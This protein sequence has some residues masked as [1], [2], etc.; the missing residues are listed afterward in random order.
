MYTPPSQYC[1][2]RSGFPASASPYTGAVGTPC[3]RQRSDVYGIA[4]TRVRFFLPFPYV[5]SLSAWS[6]VWRGGVPAWCSQRAFETF[7]RVVT[8]ILNQTTGHRGDMSHAL[9]CTLVLSIA[10]MACES[11][12]DA[13]H[14][15]PS[16]VGRQVVSPPRA[17]HTYRC[18]CLVC[19]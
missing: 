6:L 9:G 17:P 3:I 5:A 14:D 8:A 18:V 4:K 2:L 12:N 11:S 1:V 19:G 7:S 10:G 16:G 13:C 15:T